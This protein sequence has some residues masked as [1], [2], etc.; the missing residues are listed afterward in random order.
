MKKWWIIGILML[1][2]C[3]IT[4]SASTSSTCGNNKCENIE[5]TLTIGEEKT[6]K[7][8]EISHTFKLDHFSPNGEPWLSVDGSEPMGPSLEM[9]I[10]MDNFKQEHGFFLTGASINRK[11]NTPY[12]VTYRAE[13]VYFCEM[14]CIGE[15]VFSLKLYPGWNLVWG[16]IY[17][18]CDKY[19]PNKLCD[20][21]VLARYMYINPLNRYVMAGRHGEL[22]ELS[23]DEQAIILNAMRNLKGSLENQANWIYIKKE[24]NLLL[25]LKNSE[26]IPETINEISLFKGWNLISIMPLMTNKRIGEFKGDCEILKAFSFETEENNWHNLLDEI[27]SVE[28][29]GGGFAIKVSENCQFHIGSE[30]PPEMPN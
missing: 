19:Q 10:F 12:S 6:I 4:V 21:D 28:A 1:L 15:G 7:V 5:F 24:K 17:G 26:N 25:N 8:N 22:E 27:L 18:R 30:L 13:E 2:V 9:N 23:Q 3:S 29:V 11:N 16:T 14:D 20:D